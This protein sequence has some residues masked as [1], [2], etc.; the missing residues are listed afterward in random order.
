MVGIYKITNQVNGKIYIGQSTCIEERWKQHINKH[1]DTYIHQAIV[2]YGVENFKF[3]IV[4]EC[5][6]IK[7]ILDERE[8]Y[9]INFYNCVIPN[10]YNG[11]YGGQTGNVNPYCPKLTKEI[12]DALFDDLM[13]SSL[14]QLEIAEK[15]HITKDFVTDINLGRNH[16]RPDIQYPIRTL[17]KNICLKCGTKISS[18]S[19]SRLCNKCY[20]ETTRSVLRPEPWDLIKDIATSSFVAVGAKYGVSDRAVKKWCKA[21]GLP[22]LKQDVIDYYNEHKHEY[23]D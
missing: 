17:V 23:E 1:R 14:T 12:L 15:Y 13:Y 19:Q 3:E 8:Q 11:T 7:S 18:G 16:V 22:Y 2:K 4:E 9:W 10:G 21:Y 5:E 6:P 20:R